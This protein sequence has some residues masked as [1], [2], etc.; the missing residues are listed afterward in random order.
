MLG[1]NAITKVQVNVKVN[2]SKGEIE[3]FVHMYT[4]TPFNFKPG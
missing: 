1:I 2:V 4:R 3:V